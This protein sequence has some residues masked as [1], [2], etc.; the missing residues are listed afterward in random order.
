MYRFAADPGN[1][2][3][4]APGLGPSVQ[5]VDGQWFAD[6]PL[7]RVGFVFASPNAYGA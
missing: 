4:W 6:S 7:G 2:P 5:Q 1:L 3:S